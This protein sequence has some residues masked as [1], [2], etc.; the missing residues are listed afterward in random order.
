MDKFWK[1]LLIL[2]YQVFSKIKAIILHIFLSRCINV[3]NTNNYESFKFYQNF[4]CFTRYSCFSSCDRPMES[5]KACD[6]D[7]DQIG[8]DTQLVI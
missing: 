8:F 4:Y 1:N 6:A 3:Y 5:F 2:L 7:T